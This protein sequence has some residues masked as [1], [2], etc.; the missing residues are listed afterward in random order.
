M[1]EAIW[2]DL[3][4][5]PLEPLAGEWTTDFCVIGLGGSGL[6]A[7]DE[8]NALGT[9]VIG[10]DASPVGGGA[11]GRNAG[12]LLAGL[13]DFFPTMLAR[14]GESPAVGLYRETMDEIDRLYRRFPGQVSRTG[15]LRLAADA[16]ERRECAEHLRLLQHHG[17]PAEGHAGPDGEG[18]LVPSDGVFQPLSFVRSQA[19]DLLARG[20]RLFEQTA[21][22]GIDSGCVTTTHGRITC[23]AVIVAVDGGLERL[24]PELMPRVRTAR[25]QML[26]TAPAPDAPISR[27]VYWRDGFEYWQRL[28][29]G[30]VILGGFR[31]AGG[32][33]EWT[34][35]RRPSAIVQQRLEQFLRE[36]LKITAPVTHRWAASVS[37]TEDRLPVLEEVRPGVIAT[38][39]YSGTGNIVGRRCGRAAAHLALGRKSKWADLLAAARGAGSAHRG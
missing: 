8:L 23:R 37:Y 24:L 25:L 12:F 11:A 5:S 14:F 20:A 22:T 1:N 19:L 38:G 6:M 34:T 26:A 3:P 15:I 31:D 39:A 28:P 17:F 13:A 21:V 30:A 4:W 32:A 33:A 35:D 27:P 7:I 2:E 10:L 36:H 9:A 16:A 29:G 18:L